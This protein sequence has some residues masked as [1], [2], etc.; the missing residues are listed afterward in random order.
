V[1]S[2][3]I[4]QDIFGQIAA[5]ISAL[6]AIGIEEPRSR[7]RRRSLPGHLGHRIDRG[8]PSAESATFPHAGLRLRL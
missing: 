8:L 4:S 7:I 1:H 2:F 3:G 5:L 6:R